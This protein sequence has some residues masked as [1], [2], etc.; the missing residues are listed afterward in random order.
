MIPVTRIYL[1]YLK[2]VLIIAG[3]GVTIQN[4]S[5]QNVHSKRHILPHQKQI[6][7][8]LKTFLATEKGQNNALIHGKLQ[9]CQTQRS[10]TQITAEITQ[11]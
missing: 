9:M 2:T 5:K 4:A 6:H 10:D 3:P 1:L 8:D 11:T 7:G